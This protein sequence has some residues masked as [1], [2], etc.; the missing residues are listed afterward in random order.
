M[1]TSRDVLDALVARCERLGIAHSGIQETAAGPRL[2]VPDPDGTVLRFYH[3]TAPTDVFTG[4]E[5]RDGE[6]VEM[7]DTPRLAP[8]PDSSASSARSVNSVGDLL[9]Q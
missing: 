7:Y 6:V 5:F 9:D 4:V 2:D 8:A 3:F 1:P